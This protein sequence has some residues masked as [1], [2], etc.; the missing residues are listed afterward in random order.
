MRSAGPG[1][2]STFFHLAGVKRC[3]ERAPRLIWRQRYTL[4]CDLGRRSC[5]S[6]SKFRAVSQ[7]RAV[8]GDISQKRTVISMSKSVRIGATK[9]ED[10]W[11]SIDRVGRACEA[12]AQ[13]PVVARIFC[14]GKS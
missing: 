1:R 5:E 8:V 13:I 6:V 14:E 3:R 9:R 10:G 12:V 11:R 4:P 2:R 7:F